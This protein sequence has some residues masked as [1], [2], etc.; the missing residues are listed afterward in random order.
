M[1]GDSSYLKSENI[2][3][4]ESG[5]LNIIN[6]VN[7]N[8]NKKLMFEE[9]YMHT[10]CVVLVYPYLCVLFIKIIIFDL[11][12]SLVLFVVINFSQ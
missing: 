8:Y 5:V 2:E 4:S 3:V 10:L 11:I 6:Q 9:L 7:L 12:V 1:V